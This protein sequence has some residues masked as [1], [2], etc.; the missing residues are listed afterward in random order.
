MKETIHGKASK[1]VFN[2]DIIGSADWEDG[3]PKKAIV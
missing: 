1:L 2:L 3:K